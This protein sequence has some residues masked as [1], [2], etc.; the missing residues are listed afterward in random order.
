MY[1][2]RLNERF[3][4]NTSLIFYIYLLNFYLIVV[5]FGY[6]NGRPDFDQIFLVDIFI[7]CI[8]NS[9]GGYHNEYVLNNIKY[10]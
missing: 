2:V 6:I 7:F 10:S 4:C 5:R 1:S 8:H 3:N 9:L